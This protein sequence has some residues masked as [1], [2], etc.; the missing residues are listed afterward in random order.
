MNLITIIIT[1]NIRIF[2]NK[3]TKIFKYYLVTL[4]FKFKKYIF[5]LLTISALRIFCLNIFSIFYI[6][7]FSNAAE[8]T[9]LMNTPGSH[10]VMSFF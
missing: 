9:L 6:N 10:M 7:T 4:E 2:S 8:V 3:N 1:N 5:S